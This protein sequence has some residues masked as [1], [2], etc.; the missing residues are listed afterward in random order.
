MLSIAIPTYNRNQILHDNLA[1]L[2]P[3]F[4]PDVRAR[5]QLLILDNCSPTPVEETLRPLLAKFPDVP[6]EIVRNIA[7]VGANANIVRCIEVCKTPWVWVLG[8]DDTPHP[9]AIST[10]L[11]CADRNPDCVLLNF[12]TDEHRA[13]TM[14]VQG[15]RELADAMDTSADL[16]W[17]SSSVYRADELR[18]QLNFGYQY[19]YSALPHVVMFLL[20]IGDAGK[21]CLSK[22]SIVGNETRDTPPEQQWSFV[23]FALG[24]PVLLELPIEQD[25]RRK[26]VDKLL[27]TR[28]GDGFRLHFFV[29]QLVIASL[30]GGDIR[31]SLYI[32]DQVFYRRYYFD[33]DLKTRRH[34]FLLRQAVRFPHL[35]AKL[36]KRAKGVE[37]DG[38]GGVL[39]DRYGRL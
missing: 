24:F 9:D 33:R 8:D 10:I 19:L 11:E 12:A 27:T 5:C 38:G 22:R 21:C 15:L 20:A 16:P 17:I 23:N 34:R 1:H 30:R 32:F 3:Q 37:L 4:T 7:N 28:G 13:Q 31:D 26:I 25:V 6:V 14:N 36:Y 18:R 29:S 39:Q 2:L 35:A